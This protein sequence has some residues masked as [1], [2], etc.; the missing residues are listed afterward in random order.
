[1]FYFALIC[2]FWA[3]NI[4]FVIYHFTHYINLSAILQAHFQEDF[5]SFAIFMMEELVQQ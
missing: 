2:N 1:M 5:L 4:F 3:Q